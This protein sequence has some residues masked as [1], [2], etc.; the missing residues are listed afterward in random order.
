[1]ASRIRTALAREALVNGTI[2]NGKGEQ[3]NGAEK[4]LK[5]DAHQRLRD[6]DSKANLPNHDSALDMVAS[7]G[8]ALHFSYPL[9]SSSENRL[10]WMLAQ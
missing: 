8:R 6:V 10:G 2:K 7:E 1:M 9:F 4:R 5:M 3:L